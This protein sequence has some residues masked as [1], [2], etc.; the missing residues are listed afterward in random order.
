LKTNKSL[1]NWLKILNSAVLTAR[2]CPA[3]AV[4]RAAIVIHLLSSHKQH[5]TN[6]WFNFITCLQKP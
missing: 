3:S 1:G 2:Y 4:Q 6:K 5:I